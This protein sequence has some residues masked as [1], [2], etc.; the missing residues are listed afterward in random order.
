MKIERER[1][2]NWKIEILTYLLISIGI[3]L[4]LFSIDRQSLWTDELYSVYA[5]SIQN[6]SEFWVYLADDP[7]P[8]LFQILLRLWIRLIP[9][10]SEITIKLFPAI[11]SIFNL[12]LIGIFTRAWDSKK[13]FLFLCLF[14][15]SPGAIYYA[16][17]V[18]SY[19]LLLCLSSLILIFFEKL[20]SEPKKIMHLC[21]LSVLSVTISYVHLFGFIF[22]GSLYF[23]CFVYYFYHKDPI[24]KVIFFL[25]FISF[26]FYLPFL[27]QLFITSRIQTASWIDPPGIVLLLTYGSLFLYTSKKYLFL[28]A[29]LPVLFFI[30]SLV[31]SIQT[32]RNHKQKF[33]LTFG[34]LS[35]FVAILIVVST[36]L[37]SY[38][39][40]I[41]T[42]RN[43]IV[44]LPLVYLFA[45]ENLRNQIQNKKILLG[46]ILFLSL[47]F[48][49]FKKNFYIQFKE[50]W[51]GTTSYLIEHCAG[52]V[53]FSDAT[54]EYISLYM[55]WQGNQRLTPTILGNN[56]DLQQ[57]ETCV[58][59]RF[60]GGNGKSFENSD[61]WKKQK[62]TAL[63]GFSIEEFIKY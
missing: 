21:I 42:N 56:V 30:Y 1:I 35:L 58:V 11:I 29:L 45:S 57:K 48:I 6:W 28:T 55:N 26:C 27:F 22:I 51:R 9:G 62:E 38:I 40:P 16:Q 52:P 34:E 37:F 63:Y 36:T 14:S 43:W 32:K 53:V 59:K 60:M 13:R 17:E 19:S 20:I 8:P 25:G 18:R 4:R 15:L 3:F 2:K 50:D 47:S 61:L 46:L 33:Y 31:G 5:S 39:K 23:V 54:P 7:H 49:D 12:I 44:T 24:S 10:M 41:A